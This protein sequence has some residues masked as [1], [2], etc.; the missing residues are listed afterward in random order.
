LLIIQVYSLL[1]Q[2]SLRLIE[3]II[4]FATLST[5]FK[6]IY[7]LLN[8]KKKTHSIHFKTRNSPS[9]D[10]KIGLNNKSVPSA[11]STKFLELTIGS[12]L[13]W[14]IHIDHLTTKLST[15]CYVIRSVKPLM[16]HKTLLLIYHSI[17]PTVHELWNNIL[18]EF[19]SQYSNCLVKKGSN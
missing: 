15:A 11:L 8:L 16:S 6:N 14:K 3:I 19:L 7:L 10:M 13:S 17:F 9:I 1:T 12:T 2:T 4:V 5:S 18:R